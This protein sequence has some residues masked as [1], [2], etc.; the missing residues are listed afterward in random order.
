M[1]LFRTEISP[2]LGCH[3]LYRCLVL[4]LL[5]KQYGPVQF[6]INGDKIGKRLLIEK[7]F[8]LIPSFKMELLMPTRWRGIV[9]DI[10]RSNSDDIR[11][12]DWA[13]GEGIPTVQV[14]DIGSAW[15]DVE[16]IIDNSLGSK[17]NSMAGKNRLKGPEFFLLHHKFRH[18]FR[19]K[20]KYN[21]NTRH[22]LVSL[23][24]A[25]EYRQLR[26]VIDQLSRQQFQIK[27]SPGFYFKKSQRKVLKRLYPSQLDKLFWKLLQLELLPFIYTRMKISAS[28]LNRRRNW[29][30]V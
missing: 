19:V 8:T 6:L 30:W 4:G 7:G 18:F 9:F 29:A 15:L 22:V 5:L 27:V 2:T 17:G 10:N 3:S 14:G 26:R 13:K 20:R 16:Y 23:G 21:K 25:P 11:L 12:L 1:F 28:M 24:G